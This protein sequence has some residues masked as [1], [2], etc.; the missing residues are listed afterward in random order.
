L[1]KKGDFLLLKKEFKAALEDEGLFIERTTK[2]VAEEWVNGYWVFG[3]KLKTE[4]NEESYVNYVNYVTTSNSPH[5]NDLPVGNFL[6]TCIKYI[7]NPYKTH[8]PCI[9]CGLRSTDGWEYTDGEH[10]F[11]DLCAGVDI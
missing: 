10:I 1:S 6:Q 3:L 2:K 11:C 7:K 5:E 4:I 8:Q 9:K